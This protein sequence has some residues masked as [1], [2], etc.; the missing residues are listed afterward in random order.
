MK[1]LKFT[2]LLTL[3]AALIGCGAET[4]LVPENP[5]FVASKK[6]ASNAS[7]AAL[8][9]VSFWEAAPTLD[10]VTDNAQW[11]FI[12]Q[13]EPV[14]SPVGLSQRIA[15]F[16]GW[17]GGANL[18]R[19]GWSIEI[20][21]S[22]INVNA[23]DDNNPIAGAA[24]SMPTSGKHWLAVTYD[25]ST[26]SVYLDGALTQTATVTYRQSTVNEFA[27]GRAAVQ[28]SN[29]FEGEIPSAAYFNRALSLTEIQSLE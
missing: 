11:S 17:G 26:L 28:N 10:S 14:T 13:F 4:T 22:Q 7:I 20:N 16:G 1:T 27:I 25:G 9:P 21:G 12:A 6:I 3:L 2:V 23:W 18:G 8:D 19:R 24:A 15:E 29:E 5:G